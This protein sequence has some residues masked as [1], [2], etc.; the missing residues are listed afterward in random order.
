M[1]QRREQLRL[2]L[3]PDEA[4]GIARKRIGQDFDGDVAVQLRIARPI[5][6]AHPAGTDGAD[7]FIEA[8]AGTGLERQGRIIRVQSRFQSKE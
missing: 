1:I 2:A 8:E 5:D 3:E 7:D 6:L 4:V